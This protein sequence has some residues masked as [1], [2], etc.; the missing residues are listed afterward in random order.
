[1]RG[2]QGESHWTDPDPPGL[3][4][5]FQNASQ[6]GKDR[7]SISVGRLV[8][9]KPLEGGSHGHLSRTPGPPAS[10]FPGGEGRGVTRPLPCTPRVTQRARCETP[11]NAHPGDS[12]GCRDLG[13]QEQ[14]DVGLNPSS[15]LR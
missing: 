15:S 1:M 11:C 5:Q 12:E 4:Y 10:S 13:L 14:T 9:E 2:A 6:Q 8:S 7:E 3:R